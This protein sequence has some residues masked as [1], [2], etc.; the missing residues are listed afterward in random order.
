MVWLSDVK[1]SAYLSRGG[2]CREERK[3]KEEER[4]RECR[5]KLGEWWEKGGIERS[6]CPS[7]FMACS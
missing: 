3:R 1:L 6:F 5:G 7:K 2:G 4:N